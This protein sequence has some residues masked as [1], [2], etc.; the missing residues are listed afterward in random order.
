MMI[1]RIVSAGVALIILLSCATTPAWADRDRK[2]KDHRIKVIKKERDHKAEKRHRSNDRRIRVKKNSRGHVLDKRHRHDRRYPRRGHVIKR[3]P[4]G[5]HT[6]PHRGRRFYH[7]HGV[8]YRRSGARFVVIL[9]PVGVTIPVLPPFHT[10]V[11]IGNVPYYYANGMYY[12]WLPAKRVYMAT[13]PPAESEVEEESEK[14]DK[15]F[16]Y[17][18][19]GQSKEQQATDR[20]K[21]YRWSV[22]QT[23]FDPTRS[24]GN[25]PEAQYYSK[26]SD[27]HRAM[28]ACLE[29][30]G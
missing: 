3:L 25:V 18:K 7:H 28:K 19:K 20:Y 10:T 30:R 29:A 6:V 11:W 16:V 4:R 5:Y 1:S 8:W 17:P 21:C 13:N 23:G 15:L 2:D 12:I 27:Y 22:D 26:R 9:P 14:P 24:G